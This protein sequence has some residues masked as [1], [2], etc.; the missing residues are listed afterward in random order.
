MH[1]ILMVDDEQAVLR[2]MVRLLHGK[3]VELYLADGGAEAIRILAQ[4]NIDMVISDMRMPHIDGHKLLKEIKRLYP[5]TIRLMLSGYSDEK[6]MYQTVLD[7]SAKSYFLK[8]WEPSKLVQYLLNLLATKEMLEAKGIFHDIDKIISIPTLSSVVNQINQLIEHNASMTE[9]T[10]VIELDPGMSVRILQLVN[11]S[12]Y[13]R[14]IISIR[15]ATQKIGKDLIKTIINDIEY[16]HT[17]DDKSPEGLKYSLLKRHANITVNIINL[18]FRD[19]FQQETNEY[20]KQAG[21]LHNIGILF[22]EKAP[23]PHQE[24]G[25]NLLNWWGAPDQLTEGALFH[26]NPFA[27]SEKNLDIVMAV[28]LASYYANTFVGIETLELDE[29]VFRRLKVDPY[30]FDKS[31]CAAKTHLM[32]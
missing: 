22:S 5:H 12:C 6:H 8:P 11:S 31:I 18:I 9:I 14:K 16:T 24:V 19:V 3:G 4:K 23:I 32:S 13:D 29:R 27:A 7:G 10:E 25:G 20:I 15:D 30:V 2:S 1:S 26:H 28:H 21:F 17:I